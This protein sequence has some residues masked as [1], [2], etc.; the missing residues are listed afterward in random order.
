M[1]YPP[2][3]LFDDKHAQPTVEPAVERLKDARR[4]SEAEVGLPPHQITPQFRHNVHEAA[5]AVPGGDFPDPLLHRGQGQASAT[6]NKTS[7]KRVEA[8]ASPS[9]C[10]TAMQ[11]AASEVG[12][13]AAYILVLPWV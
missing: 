13:E 11:T 3:A 1:S 10:A 12:I 4:V 9:A 8:N 6:T 5:S 7:R 2:F